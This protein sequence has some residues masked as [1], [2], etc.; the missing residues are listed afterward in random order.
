MKTIRINNHIIGPGQPVYIVAEMSANHNQSIDQALKIMEA[1]KRAGADAVKTQTYT[2]DTMT[3]DCKNEYFQIKGT[4]WEGNNL[5]RL[6][7]KAFTPWEWQP[8]LKEVCDKL[9]LD[10]F[11]TP[12]DA[13]A[14]DFLEKIAVPAYK[15]ASFELVDI[16]LL[17]Q[18]ADTGKPIIMSTGMATL[19]EIDEAIHA[20]CDSGNKQIALLKCTSAYPAPIEEMNLNTI[21]HLSKAYDLPVGLSDHTLS[22]AVAVSSVALG[23]CIIE[24]HL[25]LNR[26]ENGVDSPFSIEPAEF[27][28]MVDDIRTVEKALGKVSYEITEKQ[29]ENRVFRRSLFVVRD[30]GKGEAFSNENVR[31]IR[32]GH[33]LHTRYFEHIIGRKALK[34]IKKGTPLSWDLVK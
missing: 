12:F 18:I 20:I 19:A 13:T 32:P 2:P 29:K 21:P 6:Y 7:Q 9:G 25:T 17:K 34:D 10:F 15:V 3:I 8:K 33:G 4:I 28:L 5:Y 27:K 1:A 11:S 22:S 26:K 24:K 31:S 16:P 23:G 14:V 30:I